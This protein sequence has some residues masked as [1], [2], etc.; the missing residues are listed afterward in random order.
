MEQNQS[1]K[2]LTDRIHFLPPDEGTDRPILAAIAGN[3]QTL[4]LDTGNSP[5]H[6]E[7][8]L[9]QLER[10]GISQPSVAVLTHW[11]WDHTFGGER[12]GAK[13]VA[14]EKTK[15]VLEK[16][17]PLAWTDE[18]IDEWKDK[19]SGF[20]FC[21]EMIKKEYGDERIISIRLPE[22]AFQASWETDLGGIRAAV[23][24]VGGDHAS[25][26]S[27]VYI[28][29]EKVLFLGDCLYAD[30]YGRYT[31]AKTRALLS[32]LEKYDADWYVLSHEMPM[33]KVEFQ[34]YAEL[35]GLLCQLTEDANGEREAIV[36]GLTA[37]L[38]RQPGEIELEAAAC[39][40]NGA[41]VQASAGGQ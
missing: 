33:S 9:N 24:H 22:I 34:G 32:K 29:E 41:A 17:V 6:A 10:H 28:P 35:L 11:H 25:D 19:S 21:A 5:A 36:S 31:A 15:A 1:L 20:A 8:F 18:A 12:V 40:V 38:G 4:M 14:H 7:L 23:E 39:F 37:A 27:V 13:L 2:R 16:L 3:E 30:L 26:S